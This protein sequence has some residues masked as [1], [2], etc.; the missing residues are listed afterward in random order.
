[1]VVNEGKGFRSIAVAGALCICRVRLPGCRPFA[2]LASAFE[3][4]EGAN[5]AC[6]RL[7][8]RACW[9]CELWGRRQFV[10][11]ANSEALVD[12]GLAQYPCVRHG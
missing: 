3:P 12:R 5:G 10:R 4:H 2:P 1:M 9:A 8:E 7:S 11:S 6:R